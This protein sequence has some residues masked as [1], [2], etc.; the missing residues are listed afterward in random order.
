MPSRAP[1]DVSWGRL[2]HGA[3]AVVRRVGFRSSPLPVTGS[4]SWLPYGNGR[5]YGD[6]CLNA[7]GGVLDCRDLDKFIAWDDSTGL[8]TCEGGVLYSEILRFALPR[9]WFLP[10]TPGTQFVTVGG[11]IANDVHGK[12]HHGAGS[13]G[14]H[15]EAMEVLRSDGSRHRLLAAERSPL[16]AATIGGLG[17]TGVIT[18]ATIRMRRVPGPWLSQVTRRFGSL[19]EFFAVDAE[20]KA[21]HEY[22]VAWIDCVA[23]PA[24][25]GRGIYIAGNHQ[26]ADRADRG[27]ARSTRVPFVPPFS[28]V[29]PLTLRAFN[30]AYYRR[31]LPNGPHTVH[32]R[33]FFYPLDAILDW[34]RIYGPGGL[35]QFQCAIPESASREV[36]GKLL[37]VI[38]RHAAGSFLAVLKTFGTMQPAGLL[39]FPRAGTTLA[40]DFPNLGE[41]TRRLLAELEAITIGCGGALYPAKDA[42]MSAATFRASY[43]R[44]EELLP[45][46]DP[47][48]SSSF[49]RRVTGA[50]PA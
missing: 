38:A 29:G 23:P 24:R 32:Y 30:V 17:L 46:V 36:V 43:P 19:D 41:R 48:F 10:V 47:A 12:N 28:L 5:S 15:V 31:P 6:S 21:T 25:R 45:H 22:T 49:W 14:H 50:V 27:P 37:D 33:P 39:S 1:V 9:G 8:L 35:Y 26:P 4:V 40:L 3:P 44:W 2:R 13:V 34:N 7:G 16:F 18:Q 42:L 11:A 20:L